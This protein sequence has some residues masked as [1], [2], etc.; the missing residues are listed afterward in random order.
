MGYPTHRY[1][2]V[3]Q[4]IASEAIPFAPDDPAT[5]NG[6]V[7]TLIGSLGDGV[8]LLGF[9]EGLHGGEAILLLRNRLFRRLVEAHGYSAIAIESSFPRG[10]AIDE[11]IAG[12]GPATYDEVQEV[13]FSHNSGRIDANRELI[14]W[15]RQY[16]AD[17]ARRVTLHFYGADSPTENYYADS[18][19]QTLTFALD[20]LVALAGDD[21]ADALARRER[22]AALFG[23]DAEWENPAAMMD[24]KEGIGGSPRATAL[25]IETE[26][27]ISLLQIRR[28]AL[29]ARGSEPRYLE[30]LQHAIIARQL[31]TYHAG[32]ARESPARIADLLGIRDVMIADNL[33]YA[34]TR[35]RERGKV[36]AFAHNTHLERSI[37]EM[38]VGPQLQRW[39]PAGAQLAHTLGARYAVIGSTVGV[40]EA[41]GIGQPEAGTLEARLTAAP[42]PVRFIPTY[43]GQGLPLGELNA[44]P[45][46]SA[47]RKNPSHFP[48]LPQRLGDFDWLAVLD[49]TG[50]WRGGWQLP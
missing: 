38:P 19:H 24:P 32:L 48:L 25:R 15:M 36:L 22:I 31:L 18:P 28:P 49:E 17:P 5:F 30:A 37:A 21:A 9:G 4:W 45:V 23:A 41:N 34:A 16:N 7:D 14:E 13:G 2:T 27:L 44:L 6:A 43:R 10:L 35:E 11:Y 46:R 40:S 12:R 26:E 33:T 39:W 3:E 8:E 50:Y 29:I 47:S 42:G 20:Y 1:D